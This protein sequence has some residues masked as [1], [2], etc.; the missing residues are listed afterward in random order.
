MSSIPRLFVGIDVQVARGCA[1]A[2]LDEC[3][4]A[5]DRGW[6]SAPSAGGT[7]AA[8]ASA[9]ECLERT[10]R[11]TAAI[12]IDAPRR[13]RPAPREHYW[14]RAQHAWRRRRT[15]DRGFGR[16]CEV[17]VSALGLGRPQWTPLMGACPSWMETGFA[18]FSTLARAARVVHEVFPSAAYQQLRDA[19]EPVVALPLAAFAPGPKDM[20]DA[21]VAALVVR[22]VVQGR[23]CEVGGGDGLGTIALPRPV[24]AGSCAAVLAWPA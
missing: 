5:V 2:A 13:A 16:H 19:R 14:D 11:T 9:I 21:H 4:H 12:A 20:L 22:E 10:R 23:G 15:G 3:G 1:W 18:L 7:A 8:L 24:D 6:T 17:V